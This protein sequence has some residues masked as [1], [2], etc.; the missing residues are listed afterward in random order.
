MADFSITAPPVASIG[1]EN[2]SCAPAFLRN[3]AAPCNDAVSN[4]MP[5]SISA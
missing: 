4:M 5:H 3:G 1:D 2:A